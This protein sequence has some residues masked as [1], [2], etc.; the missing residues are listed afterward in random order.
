MLLTATTVTIPASYYL[1]ASQTWN[2][3]EKQKQKKKKQGERKKIMCWNKLTNYEKLAK[4]GEQ[5]EINFV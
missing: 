2:E 4:T 5:Y 3:Q 1:E